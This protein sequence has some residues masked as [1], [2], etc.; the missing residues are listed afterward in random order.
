MPAG[1]Q[2]VLTARSLVRLCFGRSCGVVHTITDEKQF[3]KDV[4]KLLSGKKVKAKKKPDRVSNDV[5]MQFLDN[6]KQD[7][8]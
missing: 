1:L 6:N 4:M 3:S 7:T 2:P 8:N 5:M